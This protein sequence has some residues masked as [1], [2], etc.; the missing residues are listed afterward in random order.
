MRRSTAVTCLPGLSIVLTACSTTRSTVN[1]SAHNLTTTAKVPGQ[2]TALASL[3]HQIIS[4]NPQERSSAL[5]P[6]LATELHG[7]SILPRGTT[8][9]IESTTLHRLGADDATVTARTGGTH[10]GVWILYLVQVNRS[11]KLVGAYP[12]TSPK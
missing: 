10:P 8:L 4:S 2:Q 5:Y 12:A 9:A 1:T 7:R 3:Q 11:W 6:N